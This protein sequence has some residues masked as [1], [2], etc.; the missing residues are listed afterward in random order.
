MSWTA[1]ATTADHI[2]RKEPDAFRDWQDADLITLKQAQAKED[3][4][5]DITG[6]L[7]I[8]RDELDDIATT[9][10]DFLKEVLS[11]RQ[12]YWFFLEND[13]GEGSTQRYRLRHYIDIYNNYK[14]GFLRLRNTT[15]TRTSTRPISR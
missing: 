12:L 9:H 11:V 4:L 10:A 13:M 7:G 14:S 1:L 6:V 2:R 5:Q 3:V 8:G 15:L